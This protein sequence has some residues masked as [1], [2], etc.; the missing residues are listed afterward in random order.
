MS[1]IYDFYCEKCGEYKA[2]KL[3]ETQYACKCGGIFYTTCSVP[4]AIGTT[5]N[6]DAHVCET[7][8]EWID[9]WKKAEDVGKKFRSQSFP[10]GLVV[11]DSKSKQSRELAYIH[12]HKQDWLQSHWKQNGQQYK[13]G[14]DARFS[15]RRGGLMPKKSWEHEKAMG[16]E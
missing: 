4:M 9:S 8:G 1:A 14:S 15:D 2:A 12:K 3:P 16:R 11:R 10:H 6:Y 7:T 5:A 13:P